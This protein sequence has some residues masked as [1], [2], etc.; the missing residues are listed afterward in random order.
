MVSD[1]LVVELLSVSKAR[2]MSESTPD[3][4]YTQNGVK[5]I[6]GLI[7]LIKV[8]PFVHIDGFL[9]FVYQQKDHD[10]DLPS[11]LPAELS[12]SI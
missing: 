8:F 2:Y 6:I 4:E 3:L 9:T 12:H 11:S 1:S 5:L 7:Q 10:S